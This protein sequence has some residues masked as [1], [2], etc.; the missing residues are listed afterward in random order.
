MPS[1]EWECDFS[2]PQSHSHSA[3]GMGKLFM[4]T[5]LVKLAGHCAAADRL[6]ADG[7]ADFLRINLQSAS[8]Y[9]GEDSSPIRIGSGPRRFH[10]KRVRD[11][12]GY[13]QGF[14]TILR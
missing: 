1:A 10:Q 6:V 11:G 13:L 2:S 7:D 4:G 8:A 9:G 14:C 3:L 12:P 5:A